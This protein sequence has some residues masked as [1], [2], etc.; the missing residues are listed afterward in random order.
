MI[1]ASYNLPD[2][3]KGDTYGPLTF[4]FNDISGNAINF[5]GASAAAQVRKKISKCLVFGWSTDDNSI[6][7]SGNQI[8]LNPVSGVTMQIPE[9]TY[10]YDLQINSSGMTRTYIKGN[11][12]VI[13]DVTEV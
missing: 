1:P 6:T 9:L 4:Y 2:A 8:T 3:Y 12:T 10:D 5:D 11:L 7:I 13:S